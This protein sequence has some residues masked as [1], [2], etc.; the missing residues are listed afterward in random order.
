MTK[1]IAPT[2]LTIGILLLDRFNLTSVSSF[3]DV[4]RLA[5]E[6]PETDRPACQWTLLAPGKSEVR[7]SSGLSLPTDRQPPRPEQYDYLAVFGRTPDPD[8]YIESQALSYLHQA[9]EQGLKLMGI[10]GGAAALVSAGLTGDLPVCVHWF[11]H[12]DYLSTFGEISLDAECLYRE[13][14]NLITCAGGAA[15]TDLA[16]SLVQRHLGRRLAMKCQRMLLVD[17]VR[18]SDHLQSVPAHSRPIQCEVSR[19]AVRSIEQRLDE[20]IRIDDLA[21]SLNLGRRQLERKFKAAM[22][23]GIHEYTRDL[24]LKLARDTIRNSTRPILEIALNCGFPTV[25][26][27]NN[28]FKSRFGCTPTQLRQRQGKEA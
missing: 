10:G 13:E 5:A 26:H 3:I 16:I 8:Y 23:K 25:E 15:A 27:F 24:R 12:D 14:R 7:S 19:R 22:G 11:H 17:Q 20:P 21:A 4:L 18:G 1:T 28:V 2:S 6:D 9:H